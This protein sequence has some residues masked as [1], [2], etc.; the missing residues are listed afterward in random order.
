METKI[1]VKNQNSTL[2]GENEMEMA[3]KAYTKDVLNDLVHTE[4]KRWSPQ[5]LGI[6]MEYNIKDTVGSYSIIFYSD[7]GY[8][9]IEVSLDLESDITKTVA[10]RQRHPEAIIYN[11]IG[12]TFSA[13]SLQTNSASEAEFL[14]RQYQEAMKIASMFN[15][16]VKDKSVL[17]ENL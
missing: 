16:I 9:N 2:E 3:N 17:I 7:D 14:L 11:I 12:F 10:F 13:I 8:R 1:Q 15:R 6:R 4:V 5:L